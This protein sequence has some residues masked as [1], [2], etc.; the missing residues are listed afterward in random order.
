[1]NEATVTAKM[2]FFVLMN[3]ISGVLTYAQIDIEVFSI[4]AGLI[5]VDFV[6]GIWKANTLGHSITSNK[7]KYGVISKFSLIFIPIVIA[8]GAKAIGQDG[9]D[10]FVWGMNL[11]ILSEVY[12]TIGNIYTIRSGNEMPEWD[13]ISIIGKRIRLFLTGG[14]T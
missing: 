9:T 2:L 11:L 3:A 8:L 13:V 1:M 5:V 12:S 14:D 10:L 6:T 4:F 7:A